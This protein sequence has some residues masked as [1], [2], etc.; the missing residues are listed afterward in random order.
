MG[1]QVFDKDLKTGLKAVYLFYGDEK[2]LME[3]YLQ[4]VVE[5]YVEK[6]QEDFNLH[7]FDG[8]QASVSEVLD[9]CETLPFFSSHKVVIVKNAPYFRSKKNDLTDASLERILNYIKAPSSET[10]LFFMVNEA[11]DKRKKITKAV[12]GKGRIVE[13]DKLDSSIFTRW[14]HK[15]IK[16]HG[17]DL[18]H[19]VLNHLVARLAYL[20]KDHH[21]TLLEVEN[22]LQILCSSVYN[23]KIIEINDVNRLIKE[24]LEGD[25]FKLVDAVGRKNAAEGI[26]MMHELLSSGEAI[27]GIFHMICR[28]FRLLK[29]IQMLVKEGYPQQSIAKTLGLHPYVVKLIVNQI[30]LFT[31]DQLSK[32][33]L[34]CSDIDYK[35]KSTS[36]QPVLA[37]EQLMIHCS[38]L[39]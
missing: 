5:A 26:H 3:Q 23:K 7:Y 21:K 4:N 35:M 17:V 13:F 15:K 18:E 25:I 32:I 20:G 11:I 37:V 2:Y 14:V 34:E 39:K 6:G 12:E 24:P 28:Q 22:E 33:L 38:L 1:F 31:S 29:K 9:A 19:Q 10:Y 8:E 16:K 30:H 36:I 27:Q